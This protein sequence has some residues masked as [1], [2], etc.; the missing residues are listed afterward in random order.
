MK[1]V[2][3]LQKKCCMFTV[4]MSITTTISHWNFSGLYANFLH[5][6]SCI[7]ETSLILGGGEGEK[8]DVEYYAKCNCV[9]SVYIYIQYN[10]DYPN[11]QLTETPQL[12]NVD[13]FSTCW[14]S[15]RGCCIC[16]FQSVFTCQCLALY[17]V[18]FW[19]P[20]L[21]ALLVFIIIIVQYIIIPV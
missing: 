16:P 3:Y 15:P 19:S 6:V 11:C 13:S 14:V 10:A 21:K 20:V 4:V 9:N 8:G 2:F 12:R 5:S 1:F 7:D 17:S 18:W